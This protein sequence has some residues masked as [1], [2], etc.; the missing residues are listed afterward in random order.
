MLIS[1]DAE[2]TVIVRDLRKNDLRINIFKVNLNKM[3]IF[4]FIV[5]TIRLGHQ[6]ESGFVM[7]NSKIKEEFFVFINNN[8]YIYHVDGSLI[9]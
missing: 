7:F 5:T 6:Y 4:I 3:I 2:G 8:L 1:M 9:Q